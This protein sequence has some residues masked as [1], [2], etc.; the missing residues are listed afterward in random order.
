[1]VVGCASLVACK[2]DDD[3]K[4]KDP[5]AAAKPADDKAAAD[6]AAADKAAADKAA[7]DKAAADK[8]AADKA[9]PTPA[10]GGASCADVGKHI[11]DLMMADP[12][13]AK[14]MAGKKP[15]EMTAAHDA[16]ATQMASMCDADGKKFPDE[17]KS[18]VMAA[19][20]A[21]GVLA[22]K[23]AAEKAE[24]AAAPATGTAPA[25]A[26]APAPTK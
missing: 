8:A 21:K 23:E 22:C 19:T 24:K 14:K 25:P 4:A 7:A 26:P 17:V 16:M 6:K 2:K 3:A 10:P 12:E 13:M 9:A 20:D 1:M 15:E 5:K 11:A 18:C